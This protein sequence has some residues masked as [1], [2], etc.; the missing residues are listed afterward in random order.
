M[1]IIWKN[2][3]AT[4]DSKAI[5][6]AS[7]I[8]VSAPPQRSSILSP[9]STD[10]TSLRV[11]ESP[12][13][14]D[15]SGLTV[16]QQQTK[17]EALHWF[18]DGKSRLRLLS[19]Y[20]G[21]GKTFMLIDLVT[22][23]VDDGLLTW[24]QVIG[25][26]PTH[27]A[28]GILKEATE[29]KF[30]EYKTLASLLSLRPSLVEWT[31][32]QEADLQDLLNIDA[33]ELTPD[34]AVYLE[35][36]TTLKK[37][38]EEMIVSFNPIKGMETIAE[39]IQHVRLIVVDEAS[40]IDRVQ[41]AL[42]NELI[43]SSNVHPKLQVVFVGDPCQLPP[44][45]ER[46]GR[47]MDVEGFTP[48]TEVVRYGGPILDYCTQIRDG[49]V[50]DTL[51]YQ[52][53][54]DDSLMLCNYVEGIRIV[55]DCIR[56]GENVR[57]MAATNAAVDTIN[58]QVRKLVKQ[59]QNLFY[60]VGDTLITK[61]PIARDDYG[62]CRPYPSKRNQVKIHVGTSALI[63]ITKICESET[64]T[65]PFGTTFEKLLVEA[66]DSATGGTIS[67]LIHVINPNQWQQWQDEQRQAF[68]MYMSTSSRSKKGA[69][70][71]GQE[72]K[73]AQDAW[74]YLGIKNWYE[75]EPGVPITD[76]EYDGFKKRLQQNSFALKQ[77]ADECTYSY[78]STVHRAQGAGY[79]LVLL[80]MDS[81]TR[82]PKGGS[83]GTWDTRKLLYTAATR[84]RKQLVFLV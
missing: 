21:V 9:H 80:H 52:V 38:S 77:F 57:I 70:K 29:G 34:Q 74:D 1:A 40:M 11:A 4:P 79:D 35:S 2:R 12:I 27:T 30:A 15:G 18:K 63:Q 16:G 51:H 46:K 54:H 73:V 67:E 42:M 22:T 62:R 23:L 41:F 31:L 39:E 81:L 33:D 66:I 37:A 13:E 75:R 55:A 10:T 76:R 14:D 36:L 61:S 64:L 44:I 48:L 68:Q 59:Q 53:K 3:T 5:S 32:V 6:P 24:G 8:D 84:A 56:N 19:G 65:S 82:T 20:A 45:Q 50:M 17:R 83:D 25:V 71:R 43:E 58:L 7:T 49:A 69:K 78:A 60:E 28:V 26:A 47:C 72:G